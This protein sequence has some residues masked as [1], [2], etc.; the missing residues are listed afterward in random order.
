MPK[1]DAEPAGAMTSIEIDIQADWDGRLDLAKGAGGQYRY[2]APKF[3]EGSRKIRTVSLLRL[4]YPIIGLP[5]GYSGRSGNINAGRGR[6][7]L[8]LIWKLGS[9]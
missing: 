9:V 8:Y 2:L 4:G 5:E 3:H 7:F 1:Y 6:D